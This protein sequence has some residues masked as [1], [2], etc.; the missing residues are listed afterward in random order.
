MALINAVVQGSAKVFKIQGGSSKEKYPIGTRLDVSITASGIVIKWNCLW[1]GSGWERDFLRQFVLK[2]EPPTK[3]ASS[4]CTSTSVAAR[5][6]PPTSRRAVPIPPARTTASS[7]SGSDDVSALGAQFVSLPA[8]FDV[9][10]SKLTTS[11]AKFGA[12]AD[13]GEPFRLEFNYDVV[14]FD[15]EVYEQNCESSMQGKLLKNCGLL[16]DAAFKKISAAASK[17]QFAA[18]CSKRTIRF[19]LHDSYRDAR[20]YW[21]GVPE[22]DLRSGALVFYCTT[23][24][25]LPS[26]VSKIGDD[27]EEEL[28]SLSHDDDD[29]DDAD[30]GASDSDSDESRGPVIKECSVCKGRGVKP[31]SA[32]SGRGCSRCGKRGTM[33][34]KC[35]NCHGKG[36]FKYN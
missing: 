36:H 26:R 1:M 25:F 11:L 19:E 31:H 27:I 33:G 32:C 15:T 16:L 30:V 22:T 23:D 13:G 18:A 12:W 29:D 20:R 8:Y 34:E 5:P 17:S 7:K 28:K 9:D 21:V 10:V 6:P 2:M 3:L 24:S 4:R 14:E 35:T